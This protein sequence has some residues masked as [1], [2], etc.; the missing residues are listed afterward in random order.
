LGGRSVDN[1]LVVAAPE[2]LHE[3]VPGDDH[4]AFR[5]PRIG[6]NLCFSWL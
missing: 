1:E 2:I 5:S 4:L 3:R 6:L